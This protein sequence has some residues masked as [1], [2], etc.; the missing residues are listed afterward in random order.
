MN[1]HYLSEKHQKAIVEC[2]VKY[3]VPKTQSL[4]SNIT[5][6]M[7]QV[8]TDTQGN[9]PSLRSIDSTNAGVQRS[10][11][12]TQMH[13]INPPMTSNFNTP[14]L[15]SKAGDIVLSFHIDD[16]KIKSSFTLDSPTF[17]TATFGY[18]FKLRVCSTS[19]S[20]HRKQ[21]Y[22]SIYLTLYSSPYDPTLFYPF[23]YNLIICLCDQSG[24]GRNIE[25]TIKADPNLPAFARPTSEK[26]DEIGVT[27]FCP[28]DY[29]TKTESIYYKD[30]IFF[31]RVFVDFLNTSSNMNS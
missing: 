10:V 11:E 23:P 15:L 27:Q 25:A 16:E 4:A 8:S 18:I 12:Y 20:T 28:L 31:I 1:K 21:D 30:R 17:R 9:V 24:E 19:Q 22:L 7:N 14:R 3:I 6:D 29:L 13:T 26:N 5:H 2:I